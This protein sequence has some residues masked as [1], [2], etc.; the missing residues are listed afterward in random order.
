[1]DGTAADAKTQATAKER[2]QRS[3]IGM[4]GAR[5][6]VATAST[7]LWDGIAALP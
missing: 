4:R 3:V 5:V 2:K 1:M 7:R 6:L